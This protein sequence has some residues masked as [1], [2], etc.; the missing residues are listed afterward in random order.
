MF[1]QFII[2]A[3]G[4]GVIMRRCGSLYLPGRSQSLVKLKVSFIHSFIH[5]FFH[6][7][8]S[9]FACFVLFCF[10]LFCFVLF[11]FVL[12]CFVLFCFFSFCFIFN[13]LYIICRPPNATLKV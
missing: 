6:L 9:S 5:S 4:E 3:E 2:D 10:V 12:F 1:V 7:L 13:Y 8:L 11:C